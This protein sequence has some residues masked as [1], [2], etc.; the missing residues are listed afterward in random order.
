MLVPVFLIVVSLYI[1]GLSIWQNRTYELPVIHE[2]PIY[3]ESEVKTTQENHKLNLN[4]ATKEELMTL[5]GI[6]EKTAERILIKREQLGAFRVIEQLQEINGIGE[7]T[8][9]RI[10]DF[11]TVE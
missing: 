2:D 7:V 6:G 8:F 4:S 3:A 5:D 9:N 11:I 1:I 10:K